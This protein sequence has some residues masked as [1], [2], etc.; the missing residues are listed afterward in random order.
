MRFPLTSLECPARYSIPRPD[1]PTRNRVMPVAAS[2]PHLGETQ[3][4][5]ANQ[6]VV[7]VMDVSTVGHR[8]LATDNDSF[9]ASA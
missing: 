3:R 5:K 1:T 4:G 8:L 2:R 7:S 6:R 9:G